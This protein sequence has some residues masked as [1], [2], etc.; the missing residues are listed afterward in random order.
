[1]ELFFFPLKSHTNARKSIDVKN[2]EQR[3]SQVIKGEGG[4]VDTQRQTLTEI[5]NGVKDGRSPRG[6]IFWLVS[7]RYKA[8]RQTLLL[9]A[10][11]S[12]DMEVSF[13]SD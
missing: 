7:S 5:I 12:L 1:M 9:D 8:Q 6:I 13:V 2:T 10:A 3:S 4:L 11:C